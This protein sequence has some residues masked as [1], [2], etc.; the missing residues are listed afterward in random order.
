MSKIIYDPLAKTWYNYESAGPG[1]RKRGIEV[2]K[3]GVLPG[4]SSSKSSTSSTS[5]PTTKKSSEGSSGKSGQTYTHPETGAIGAKDPQGN[6]VYGSLAQQYITPTS[7]SSYIIKRGDT[8]SGL[9]RQHGTTVNELMRLNPNI[10]NPNLIYAG[11]SLNIPGRQDSGVNNTNNASNYS[12]V[13][14]EEEAFEAI[15]DNQEEDVKNLNDKEE[16]EERRTVKDIMEEIEEATKPSVDRPQAPDYTQTFEDY[17]EEYGVTGLENQLNDLRAQEQELM[18]IKNKR[19]AAERGKTVA[20]NV[21]AGRIGEVERQENERLA[22]VQRSISNVTNQLNTKYNIV[23]SLMKTEQMD[24]NT[25]TAQYD[26]E[27]SNNIAM[28]NAARGIEE[29]EKAEYEKQLDNARASAQIILNAYSKSGI[30]HDTLSNTEKTNLTKLGVQSGLGADF[31]INALKTGGDKEILTTIVAPDKTKATILYKDGTTK[32]ISTGITAKEPTTPTL[33][34]AEQKEQEM[35]SNRQVIIEDVSYIT[36]ADGKVD[37]KKMKAL[38]QDIALNNPELLTWFDKAF[39]PKD[40][41]NPKYYPAA[42]RE[43]KWLD[44]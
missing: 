41:L 11:K 33:T 22:V 44:K 7:S 1:A 5:K 12:Q 23:D 30:T 25:A 16:P 31:F 13:N 36:G 32:V 27:M 6:I 42:I 37:P 10:S 35:I 17:R 9:A 19:I 3:M 24:Y 28:F 43:N 8:L 29:Y 34:K 40:M 39:Q 4:S 14:S 18:D 2:P 26:K 38:R 15:N 20:T 21:I